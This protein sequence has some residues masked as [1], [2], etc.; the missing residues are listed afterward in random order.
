VVG[1][2]SAV[3]EKNK[4]ADVYSVFHTD[5][6]VYNLAVVLDTIGKRIPKMSYSEISAFL[7]KADAERSR[8]LTSVT[9]QLKAMSSQEAQKALS[10]SSFPLTDVIEGRPVSIY[11]IVPPAKLPS[12]FSLLRVWIGTL[13]LCVMG[14]RVRPAQPTLF[15]LDE[16]AMLGSFPLLETAITSAADTVFWSGRYGMT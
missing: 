2:L 1:Y 11:V 6:V 12:H 14:R 9:S 4:F 15:L 7:Q 10:T 3:P 5:D 13:L 16:C 8:I